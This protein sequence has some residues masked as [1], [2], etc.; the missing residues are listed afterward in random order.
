MVKSEPSSTTKQS[1][2]P[3]SD[4]VIN[5]G[6]AIEVYFTIG[7]SRL[8]RVGDRISSFGPKGGDGE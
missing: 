5:R 2:G 1:Q 7:V 4:L 8:T 3:N 6:V